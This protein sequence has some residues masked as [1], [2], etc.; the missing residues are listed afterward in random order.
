M[1]R[2]SFLKTGAALALS[3]RPG[4]ASTLQEGMRVGLIGC[5]GRGSGAAANAMRADSGNKLVAMADAF[6]WLAVQFPAEGGV[7]GQRYVGTLGTNL[8]PDNSRLTCV[9]TNGTPSCG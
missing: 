3:A 2:R 1:D 5:G 9:F 8:P 4:F 7:T 6:A